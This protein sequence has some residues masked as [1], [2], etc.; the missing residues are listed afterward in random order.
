MPKF[1]EDT[2]RENYFGE[3]PREHCYLADQDEVVQR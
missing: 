3:E 1:G 2:G